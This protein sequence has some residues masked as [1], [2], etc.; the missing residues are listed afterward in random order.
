MLG[1]LA[2]YGIQQGLQIG[3]WHHPHVSKQKPRHA[4]L[5]KFQIDIASEH[6]DEDLV[7]HVMTIL[8]NSLLVGPLIGAWKS[9]PILTLIFQYF[10]H[11]FVSI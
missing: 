9:G 5:H 4:Y 2:W 6:L 8:S 3:I 10:L 1:V 11:L 7:A